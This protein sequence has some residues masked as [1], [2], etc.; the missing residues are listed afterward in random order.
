ML[1]ATSV[2]RRGTAHASATVDTLTLTHDQR[3]RRRIAMST[4]GG[5]SFLLDLSKATV[6]DEG[7]AVRFDDG[8]LVLVKAAPERLVEIRADEPLTLKRIIWHIGNR[9]VPAE[10]TDDAVYI[11]HDHV[12]V[13]MV[14]A[15]GARTSLVERPFRPERGAYE[16]DA[17]HHHPGSGGP[18]DAAP[19]HAHG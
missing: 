13:G 3:H 15:L 16:H 9:H 17:S 4:D 14:V 8:R 1:R 11:A 10:I 6:L 2:L 7:D 12:L 19:H 5:L 18:A